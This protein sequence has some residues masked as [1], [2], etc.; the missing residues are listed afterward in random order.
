MGAARI[1]PGQAEPLYQCFALLLGE[2]LGYTLD[3]HRRNL[4][5][6]LHERDLEKERVETKANALKQ[7]IEE[8]KATAKKKDNF[9]AS[10]SHEMRTVRRPWDRSCD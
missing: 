4:R 8:L 6:K 5:L 9:V 2:L 7:D 1:T 10:L 3:S